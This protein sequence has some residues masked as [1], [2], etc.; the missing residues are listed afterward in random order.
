MGVEITYA[1]AAEE[2]PEEAARAA[3]QA[4]LEHGGRPEACIDAIL[5]SDVQLA[6]LHADFLDDPSETDVIAF[7][8]GDEEEG[9]PA[10]EVYVSVDRARDVAAQRGVSVARELALYLVHGSLHLCGFD[11]HEENERERMRDAERAVLLGLGY[12]P[13]D[14][15]HEMNA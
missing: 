2:L 12:P 13:D 9:G 6:Q 15:P 14:A 4:A 3:V 8:L 10:G 5:V 11:D 7:D 1:V